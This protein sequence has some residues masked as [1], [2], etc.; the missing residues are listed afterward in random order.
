[1]VGKI[2]PGLSVADRQVSSGNDYSYASGNV[3]KREVSGKVA[4]EGRGFGT[5]FR[6]ISG[7]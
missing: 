6:K 2:V 7:L 4:E 1:M 3:N 5:R